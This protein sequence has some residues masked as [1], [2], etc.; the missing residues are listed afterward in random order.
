MRRLPSIIQGRSPTFCHPRATRSAE[1]ITSSQVAR[2][3]RL[4]AQY[5]CR[6][7]VCNRHEELRVPCSAYSYKLQV[8]I[9]T[10]THAKLRAAQDL[11][12]H[13]IPSGDVAAVLDRAL[14]LLISDL[15]RRRCASV[16]NPRTKDGGR[17]D[18]QTRHIPAAIRRAVW[19][20]D[21]GRC[22]FVRGSRRSHR[23]SVSRVSPRRAVHG[24]WIGGCR[25]YP[26][27]LPCPQSVRV[28][29]VLRRTVPCARAGVT[30]RMRSLKLIP[31]QAHD[32]CEHLQ[33][34]TTGG[35]PELPRPASV[36]T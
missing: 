33:R 5:Y 21:G 9:S 20:R 19:R 28:R 6:P 4:A 8:T 11:L 30:L 10:A 18:V 17:A 12:R 31:G 36:R 25:Q 26:A 24:R 32:F 7:R 27:A 29:V 3:L 34:M 22:A 23:D 15:E 2:F 14:A 1:S 35:P 13:T 16:I